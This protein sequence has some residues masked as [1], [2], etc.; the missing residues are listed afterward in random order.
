MA[1][2]AQQGT[3][4]PSIF[5]QE[6]ADAIFAEIG[7]GRGLSDICRDAGMPNRTT[8]YRWLAE[9]EAFRRQYAVAC[10]MRAEHMG[11]QILDIAAN[12]A[13]EDTQR[14]RLM[15]DARKWMMSK[16]APKKYGE[17]IVNEHAGPDGGGI[18][19]KVT[20]DTDRAKALAALIA[21]TRGNAPTTG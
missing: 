5:S 6:L 20:T 18:P 10:E 21:K 13:P 1:T 11:D 9:D 15:I 3:G 8:V 14:A 16:L 7:E 17:K 2:N 19:V 12:G 4:R